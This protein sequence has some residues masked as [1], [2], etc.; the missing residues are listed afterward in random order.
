MDGNFD[1]A[2]SFFLQGL[3]HYQGER[4]P[5]AE[6]CFAASLALLPGRAST[7]TNLGATRLK[8]GK[9]QDAADLLYEALS[10]E[11]DNVEALGHLATA[12]AE[13]GHTGQ[14]LERADHVL[15]LNPQL[16]PVWSLRG[17]LLRD[18]GRLPEARQSF[19]KAIACGGDTQLNRYYLAS[20]S[21]QAAPPTAPAEYVQALF[22]GY[23]DG[24][25]EHLVEVLNYRA[26]EILVAELSRTGREFARA[27][28]L[29]CGTGLCGLK[30]WPLVGSLDGVD[31]S[32]NMVERAGQRKVYDE[33]AHS[34]LVSYLNT[35][36][37]RYDL[38]VATDVFIYVG[39]LEPVFAGAARVL[40]AGGLFCFSVEAAAPD[41]EQPVLRPSLRYA[42]SLRY[43]QKL[44]GE[45]GFEVT[46]TA[47]HPIRK[48]QG[49]SIPG[50]FAWLVR[51]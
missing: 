7:L 44:A 31:L 36:P 26:P 17:T 13:L 27:L 1:Q 15:R 25:E 38:V 8:L 48:D 21:G 34:D 42:H 50:L 32:A 22:D 43:I 3:E 14:A 35:T 33:L 51:R 37:R 29:G 5:K 10:Q 24:F 40:D 41:A 23:A 12:L 9:C 46:A 49:T 45:F 6:R 11:P 30:L 4:F 16:A 47:E 2:R 18:M 28:D 19:E 39:A 20:V